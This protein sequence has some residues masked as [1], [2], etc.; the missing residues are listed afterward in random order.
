MGCKRPDNFTAASDVP[1]EITV[2]QHK[3][4][5]RAQNEITSAEQSSLSFIH[6]RAGAFDDYVAK[7]DCL[8]RNLPRLYGLS[9][10]AWQIITDFFLLKKS[11]VFEVD[12]MRIIQ[13]MHALF[14]A[15]N[16]YDGREMMRN[17]ERHG[18]INR[19]QF[20]GRKHHQSSRAALGKRLV[21]DLMRL[22]VL[23]G[24]LI[25]NDAKSC[26]DRVVHAA[27][28]F[29][30][31]RQG[32]SYRVMR[33]L[34][35]TLQMAKHHVKTAFGVSKRTYG[36]AHRPFGTLP[37]QYRPPFVWANILARSTNILSRA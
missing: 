37:H 29:A 15:N 35:C 2:P 11:Q 31:A 3:S 24:A 17:G 22:Q 34:F 20:G 12:K 14:N 7:I 6:L 1:P 27:A 8:L 33:T 16:K 32:L 28:M 19:Q 10:E 5:W 21:L 18:S 25:C 9:P 30:M 26:F 23:S 13:L 4:Q 36:G